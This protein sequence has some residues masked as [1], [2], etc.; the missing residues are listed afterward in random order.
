MNGGHG[1]ENKALSVWLFSCIIVC[2]CASVSFQVFQSINLFPITAETNKSVILLSLPNLQNSWVLS[3][4]IMRLLQNYATSPELWD[5]TFK[6]CFW[7]VPCVGDSESHKRLVV[8]LLFQKHTFL[9]RGYDLWSLNCLLLESDTEPPPLYLW[10]REV[11]APP[12]PL[13]T[14]K[15][16]QRLC[17]ASPK[18]KLYLDAYHTHKNGLKTLTK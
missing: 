9:P 5:F 7:R 17:S 4:N 1:E 12:Q 10:N 16:P 14:Q 11:T 6:V 2:V 15:W 18:I 8:F 3:S 13:L